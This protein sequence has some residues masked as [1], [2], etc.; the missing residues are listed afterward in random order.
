MVLLF[1]EF[2]A[3]GKERTALDEHGELKRVVSSFLQLLDGFHAETLTVAATNHQGLLDP[4]LWRRFDEIVLFSPPSREEIRELLARHF[5]QLPLE[6]TV[7]LEQLAV[8]LDG[9][10]HA[11][12]ERVALDALKETILEGR[13][14]VGADV[15]AA[16]V[17][18]QRERQA[19]SDAATGDDA[20]APAKTRQRRKKSS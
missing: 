2:D 3:I 7:G 16:A 15:I 17:A 14:R 20:P 13:D 4:A 5:R 11:A 10:S 1:D 18:R 6:H 12:V 19:V 9:A 8:S